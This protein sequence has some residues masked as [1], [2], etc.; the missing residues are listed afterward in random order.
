MRRGPVYHTDEQIIGSGYQKAY[1]REHHVTASKRE[2]DER[3]TPF[4]EVDPVICDYVE[5]HG[6]SCVKEMLAH[7]VKTDGEITAL[8]PFQ[9]LAHF[10]IIA[11]VG[12]IF[13]PERDLPAGPPTPVSIAERRPITA[14]P[15]PI[16]HL[17]RAWGFSYVGSVLPSLP[18]PQPHHGSIR[19]HS[20]AAPVRQRQSASHTPASRTRPTG[21]HHVLTRPFQC[22]CQRLDS[23]NQLSTLLTP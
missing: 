13:D 6:D 12:Y 1:G 7:Y 9:M 21:G 2:A 10:F 18:R 17:I 5:N 3:G 11:S 8:F 4:I 15:H 22:R 14:C 20:T 23:V 16:P 19:G